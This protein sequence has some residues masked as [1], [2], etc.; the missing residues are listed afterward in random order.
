MTGLTTVLLD[1]DGTL[2]DSNDAHASAWRAALA[3]EGVEVDLD[4]LRR[5][6]GLGGD[7]IVAALGL[8]PDGERA[9]RVERRK[10]E[11]F[12][13]RLLPTVQPFAGTRA[14]VERIVA[15]GLRPVAASSA[16]PD[17]LGDLL[18]RAGVD[19][20]VLSPAPPRSSKPAPDVVEAALAR[21]GARPDEAV[22]VGDTPYD[23]EAAR[24]AGVPMVA[25][26]CGG[27]D[28]A[29]GGPVAVYADPEDLLLHWTG[30]P[31]DV[32]VAV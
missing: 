5:M 1:I 14:L 28:F 7:R 24:R 21:A 3:T 11:I 20:V 23:L 25:L 26:R 29:E 9:K 10:T 32:G 22:L 17:E 18:A 12:R 8:D 15:H 30:S 27:W 13:G 2:L 19:D 4:R 6:I 16:A 31:L